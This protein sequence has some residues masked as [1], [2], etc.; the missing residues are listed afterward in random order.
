[1]H[2]TLNRTHEATGQLSSGDTAKPKSVKV[3]CKFRVGYSCLVCPG[4]I[5]HEIAQCYQEAPP[6]EAVS[7]EFQWG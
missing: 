5:F 4:L 1:M 7:R 3:A 6:Y 2:L